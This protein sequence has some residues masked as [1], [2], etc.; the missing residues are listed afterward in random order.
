MTAMRTVDTVMVQHRAAALAQRCVPA[1]ARAA[2]LRLAVSMLDLTTLEG[3]DTPET[4]RALCRAA[5]CPCPAH[6]EPPVPPVAAVCVYPALVGI[7]KEALADSPVKV[8]AVAAAFPAGQSTL[9]VRLADVRGAVE[10]GAD[11][12]DIVLNR[13]AFLAGKHDLAKREIR[14]ARL[15]CGTA[16]LKIILETGELETCDNIRR[17]S[18]LAI[19]AAASARPI[20]DGEVFIKTSTGKISPAATPAA[21]L[22]MLQAIGDHFRTT[23]MRIGIKP[24]GGIRTAREAL[25]YLVLVKETLGDAWLTPKLF[26]FGAS[27]LLDDLLSGIAAHRDDR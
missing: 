27:S 19:E 3:R 13:A 17:A 2:A 11:E 15:A 12:I 4:V 8:A 22:V 20:E 23:G 10:A 16:H 26:R 21:T 7:A 6:I 18:D 9:P 25:H 1:R 14:Q 5:A 24:A